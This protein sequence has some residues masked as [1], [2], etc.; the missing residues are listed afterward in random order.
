[1]AWL[2]PT[3]AEFKIRYP[4]FAS[5]PDATLQAFLDEATGEVG[6]TWIERTRSP[7]IMALAAHLLAVQGLGGDASAGDGGVAISGAV[8]RRKVG[9]VE[10]EFAGLSTGGGG[11]GIAAGYLSTAYGR[12]YLEWLRKNFPAVAVV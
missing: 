10:V 2:P 6:P 7:A 9:D 3:I 8:K 1:M 12:R 11:S 4:E 5:V